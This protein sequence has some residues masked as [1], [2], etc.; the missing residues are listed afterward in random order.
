MKSTKMSR[1][2]ALMIVVQAAVPVGV[3]FAQRVDEVKPSSAEPRTVAD[4]GR[5]ATRSH[6][7]PQSRLEKAK[8]KFLD[9]RKWYQKGD[10]RRAL[11]DF[12]EANRLV[13]SA[14]LAYNIGQVYERLGDV[15]Q[16]IGHFKLYL[17]RSGDDA[18]DRVAVKARVD[19]LRQ[20]ESRRL[21][22]LLD[23]PAQIS[24]EAREQFE[25]AKALFEAGRYK[26]ALIAFA[27]AQRLSPASEIS[28]NLALAAERL[29]RLTDAIDYYSSF[30]ARE[31]DL[32]D[33]SAIELKIA[34]LKEALSREQGS[35]Q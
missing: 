35:K 15:E 2:S 17:S 19:R 32:S 24:G 29:G 5:E 22:Q 4:G 1:V 33:K 12:Q 9:A 25:R 3:A 30:L 16:A 14:E 28:F 7:D 31:T 13:P 20:A 26:G 27:A 18:T 6:T 11:S 34:T 23:P 21:F 10:L 8:E